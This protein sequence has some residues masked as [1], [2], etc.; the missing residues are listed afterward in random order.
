MPM[1]LS[2]GNP[3]PPPYTMVNNIGYNSVLGKSI[4][5]VGPAPCTIFDVP[6]LPLGTYTFQ[7]YI[8]DGGSAGRGVSLTNAIVLKVQ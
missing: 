7:G 8:F 1:P 3:K 6:S 2:N 4:L 5:D